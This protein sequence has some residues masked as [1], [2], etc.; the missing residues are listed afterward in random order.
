M[1]SPALRPSE[2]QDAPRAQVLWTP[3]FWLWFSFVV[4]GRAAS[5]TVVG[6]EGVHIA[7]SGSF[8][9]RTFLSLPQVLLF[10]GPR[11]PLPNWI[12][13]R[14]LRRHCQDVTYHPLPLLPRS[15]DFFL[16]ERGLAVVFF[17]QDE[18]ARAFFRCVAKMFLF[19]GSVFVIHLRE[20][21]LLL[22]CCRLV[23]FGGVLPMFYICCGF[24]SRKCLA[25]I[26]LILGLIF[27]IHFRE[28]AFVFVV[29]LLPCV[30]C[31]VFCQHFAF[32]AFW[33]RECFAKILFF[34]GLVFEIRFRERAFVVLLR[35]SVFRWHFTYVFPYPLGFLLPRV[36]GRNSLLLRLGV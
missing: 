17:L 3:P 32:L 34:L 19:L 31:G 5:G 25:K 2:G 23:L 24:C 12:A 15:S 4:F 29:L 1:V 7:P 36:L 33:F 11:G 9:T 26:L 21:T 10:L 35:S 8:F 28:Q 30:F 13:G 18:S 14:E 6:G 16:A 27:E 22:S 20:Q